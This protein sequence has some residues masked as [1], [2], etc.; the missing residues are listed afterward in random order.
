MVWTKQSQYIQV[1]C[2]V[3][4]GDHLKSASDLGIPLVGIGLMYKQGYFDQTI[5]SKG[6][7]ISEYHNLD[8]ETMPINL[9]KDSEG[10]P[11]EVMVHIKS[12][13]VKIRA[14]K[15]KVGRVSLYLLDSDVDG[16]TEEQKDI[17]RKLYRRWPRNENI[18]GNNTSV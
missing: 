2:G 11:V 9:V 17:T 10:K 13:E 4:S 6:Q 3:L 8:L 18:S 15:L 16:N 5:D 1:V 12:E 7:Q 14:W